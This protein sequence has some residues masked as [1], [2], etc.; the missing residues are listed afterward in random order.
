MLFFFINLFLI[1][2]LTHFSQHQ[3]EKL[4][5]ILIALIAIH[6]ETSHMGVYDS[7]CTQT[8]ARRHRF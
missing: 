7:L 8:H 6:F 3:R 4:R 5:K 1:E 2:W